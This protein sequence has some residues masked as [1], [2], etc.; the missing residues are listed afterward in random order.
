MSMCNNVKII[1]PGR[2]TP[3]RITPPEPSS[4]LGLHFSAEIYKKSWN[5]TSYSDPPERKISEEDP[6][7]LYTPLLYLTG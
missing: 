1:T 5:D 6:E 2:G 3:T 7:T 4:R